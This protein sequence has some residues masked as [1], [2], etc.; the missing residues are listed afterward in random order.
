MS[1]NPLSY[2]DIVELIE[3]VSASSQFSEFRIRQGDLEIELRRG[4]AGALA[5]AAPAPALLP[6][7]ATAPPVP[8][9]PTAASLSAAP[10]S[11]ARAPAAAP[12]PADAVVIR[13]PMVGSFYRCPE[14]G[15]APFVE[16]GQVVDADTTVCIIE[17]MKLMN[18][19]RAG[20]P[21]RVVEVLVA[22]GTA[23]EYGQPL[24]VIQA[25]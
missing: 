9:V 10:A 23:V 18:S 7:A 8:P 15:A 11:L 2:Q 25:V 20:G 13:A 19:I 24:I 21:G 6:M 4:A 1:S 5:V 16:L 17:V 12:W 14:P 3:L 22:D